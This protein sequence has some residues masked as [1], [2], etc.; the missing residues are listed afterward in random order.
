[1]ASQLD[2][3]GS[4]HRLMRLKA[5]VVRTCAESS[6]ILKLVEGFRRK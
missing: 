5:P 1:M 4:N 6:P 3:L 2:L